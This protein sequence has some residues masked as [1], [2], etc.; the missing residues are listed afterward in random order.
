LFQIVFT[1]V[2][3]REACHQT[4]RPSRSNIAQIA[5]RVDHHAK[6]SGAMM[7]RQQKGDAGLALAAAV[8]GVTDIKNKIT[9]KKRRDPDLIIRSGLSNSV[10]QKVFW[11]RRDS[12]VFEGDTRNRAFSGA[13]FQSVPLS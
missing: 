11:P 7:H 8:R 3:L 1:F 5:S 13:L 10:I 2:V 4:W 9:V 6:K 12:C